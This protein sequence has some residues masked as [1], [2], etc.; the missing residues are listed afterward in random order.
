MSNPT[1]RAA[2][3]QSMRSIR[4]V[5]RRVAARWLMLWLACALAL[6][7]CGA[8]EAGAGLTITGSTSV[9]PFIEHLAEIY[10]RQHPGSVI[11]VQSLGSTAGIRAAIDGVAEIGISSRD[12]SPDEAAQL[13]QSIIARD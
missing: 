10:Q 8:S 7:G 9:A 13:D 1:V 12:L 11:N 2:A 4:Q 3:R 5:A 6:A